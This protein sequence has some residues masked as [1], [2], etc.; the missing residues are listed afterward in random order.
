MGDD[1]VHGDVVH[2][3]VVGDD[4]VGGDV[5]SDDG[6]SGDVVGGDVVSD[7]VVGGDAVTRTQTTPVLSQ[8]CI[9]GDVTLSVKTTNAEV[10]Q[11]AQSVGYS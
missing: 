11:L 1:V 8:L 6:V 7:N 9:I 4:V 3:D 2:G 10:L 5:V